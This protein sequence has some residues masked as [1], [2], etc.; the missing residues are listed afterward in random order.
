MTK[1]TRF[2]MVLSTGPRAHPATVRHATLEEAR[3]EAERVASKEGAQVFVLAS[4][5]VASPT[6]PPVEWTDLGDD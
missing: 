4:V 5:G 6:T 1:P 3:A 2:Y